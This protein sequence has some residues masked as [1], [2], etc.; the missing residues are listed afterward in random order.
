MSFVQ[1]SQISYQDIIRQSL[2]KEYLNYS[3]FICISDIEDL[4]HIYWH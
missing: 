2:A 1:I 4:V 3:V